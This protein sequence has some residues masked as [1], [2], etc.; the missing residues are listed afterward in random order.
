MKFSR[1]I[2]LKIILKVTKNQGFSLYLEDTLFEKPRG[3]GGGGGGGQIAPNSGFRVKALSHF[4]VVVSYGTLMNVL[5]KILQNLPSMQKI[6]FQLFPEGA[7]NIY[8]LQK[9]VGTSPLKLLQRKN[10]TSG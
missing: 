3:G 6:L 4:I 5:L 1:K 9:S 10:M 2:Y 7:Q 8:R